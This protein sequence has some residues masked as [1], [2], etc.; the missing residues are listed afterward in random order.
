MLMVTGGSL[1]KGRIPGD[2]SQGLRM[3][4]QGMPLKPRGNEQLL[5]IRGNLR[6]L[7]R[8]T[9]CREVAFGR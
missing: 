8:V 1:Q 9:F 6:R 2:V 7:L 4:P 5:G 3:G